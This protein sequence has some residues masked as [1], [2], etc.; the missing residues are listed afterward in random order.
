MYVC[1]MRQNIKLL[2]A[3][4]PEEKDYRF[5]SEN[6][7]CCRESQNCV[8]HRC[9]NCPGQSQLQTVV[10][11]LFQAND[12]DVE[13]S[14]VYNQ[15]IHD[16][17]TKI[18]SMTSTVGEFTEKSAKQQICQDAV[19]GFHRETD[20]ATLHP[21]VVYYRT[22][23]PENIMKEECVSFCAIRDCLQHTATTVHS[24]ISGIIRHLVS[25]VLPHLRTV[26]YFSDG[27]SSQYKNCKNFLN[28]RYHEE[29]FHVATEWNFIILHGKS[30]CDGIHGTGKRLVARASLQATDRNHI[31]T[32][33]VLY[34][35]AKKILQELH[36][37][38]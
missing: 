20:Q 27:V 14:I 32:P 1:E 37:S 28:L 22:S 17:R 34:K 5:I 8:L 23:G 2:A 11:E 18:V 25:D 38:T 13:D 4:L 29:V 26:Y 24:F 12:F 15:W 21:F 10:E 9:S 16:G 33:E 6:V 3:V 30:P 35:W 7:V 31:L 19:Q 36:S